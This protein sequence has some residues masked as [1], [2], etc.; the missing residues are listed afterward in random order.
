MIDKVAVVILN[1]NG[2]DFLEKFLPNVVSYSRGANIWVID[3]ASTDSSMDFLNASY[4]DVLVVQ[5][6]SNLG[7]AGGYQEGL[8]SIRAEYYVLL[9]SDVEV[10]KGWLEPML[11]LLEN[12]PSIAACQ[13]KILSHHLRSSFEY[14]GAA[15]GFID[16]LGYPFCR[17]RVF[18]TIE[19]DNGQY[20]D[21]REIFWATGA[22]LFVRSSAYHQAGGLDQRFFAHMEEIDLC[23]RLKMEG[24][25]VYYQG[26]SVVYHVGGGTLDSGN[27]FKTYLNFRNSILM[28]IKNDSWNSLYWKVPLRFLIDFL[29]LLRLMLGGNFRGAMAIS[30]AHLF[31]VQNLNGYTE[32][33]LRGSLAT[34]AGCYKGVAPL[35]YPFGQK[36]F[37]SLEGR[38]VK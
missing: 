21:A 18:D 31:I 23:W 28:L 15:G 16:V 10:T 1:Y 13:P 24:F 4:P 12:D 38:I 27:P 5:L 30:K 17:G 19:M 37:K 35:V 25:K 9:N 32:N 2:R 11:Q 8:R 6:S 29:I 20:N 22:C 7:Y 34:L 26:L 3:N 14:A 33:R 36:E